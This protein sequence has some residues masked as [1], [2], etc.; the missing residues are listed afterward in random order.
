[1]EWTINEDEGG[2]HIIQDGTYN[3]HRMP[4]ELMT[5]MTLEIDGQM[6][7]ILLLST[8]V[9][10][11]GRLIWHVWEVLIKFNQYD[12]ECELALGRRTISNELAKK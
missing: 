10:V 6:P 4:R 8:W 9:V 2:L 5:M 11:E 7:Y 3:N 1:M 12:P